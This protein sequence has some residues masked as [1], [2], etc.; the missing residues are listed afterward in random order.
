MSKNHFHFLNKNR[1]YLK[2]SKVSFLKNENVLKC[3]INSI[4]YTVFCG[5][6]RMSLMTLQ[7]IRQHLYPEYL[8]RVSQV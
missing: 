6:I 2:Y 7:G 5:L 4:P 1:I 8:L 3:K